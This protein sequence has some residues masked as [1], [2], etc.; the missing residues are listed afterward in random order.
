MFKVIYTTYNDTNFS[1]PLFKDTLEEA[2]DL[3]V[4]LEKLKHV[5]GVTIEEIKNETD[6]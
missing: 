2:K 3:K 5:T 4:R 1:L 6:S